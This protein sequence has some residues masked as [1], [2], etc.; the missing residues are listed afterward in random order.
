MVKVATFNLNNLFSRWNFAA[1]VQPVARG[2]EPPAPDRDWLEAPPPI[3]VVTPRGPEV[4]EPILKDGRPE[5]I[6]LVVDGQPA[7]GVFRRFKGKVINGKKPEATRWLAHRLAAIDADVV[8]LQEVEDQDALDAFVR[9]DLAA[10][11]ERYRYAVCIEGNDV[12]EIEVAL[13]SR[14]PIGRLSSW[15]FVPDPVLGTEPVF[16][17]D[18]LQVDLMEGATRA[19]SV[20]VNHLKSN[21]IVNEWT[22]PPAEREAEAEAN[23]QRRRRQ[24]EA[25]VRILRN[26]RLRTRVV[27][28]GDMNDAPDACALEPLHRAGLVDALEEAVEVRGPGPDGQPAAHPADFSD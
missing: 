8:C 3:D 4:R 9:D 24:C 12:R 10:V 21:V 16:S 19:L 2:D 20:F 28:A 7:T 18:L 14:L 22:L 15:R 25:V 27:V 6:E 26:L 13:L 17:R 1:E 23:R 5:A 11:S